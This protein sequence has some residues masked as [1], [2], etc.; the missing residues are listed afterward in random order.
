MAMPAL[1]SGFVTFMFTDIEGSTRL[2]QKLGDRFVTLIAEHDGLLSEAVATH[3]G[4]VAVRAAAAGV[5][6]A[7]RARARSRRAQGESLADESACCA[8]LGW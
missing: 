8:A 3:G 1:P 6:R 5:L 4:V 2:H 7:G